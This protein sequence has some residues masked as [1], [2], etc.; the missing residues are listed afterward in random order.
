MYIY[1][2]LIHLKLK[3]YIAW[4]FGVLGSLQKIIWRT[5][6]RVT[7]AFRR[8]IFPKLPP[9]G[10]ESEVH[11]VATGVEHW[12][13]Q[14]SGGSRLDRHRLQYIYG[15]YWL[16][17]YLGPSLHGCQSHAQSGERA[18]A[19]SHRKR[20]KARE[21]ELQFL[22]QPLDMAKHSRRVVFACRCRNA[23]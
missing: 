19:R 12:R 7:F 22:E 9:R 8:R 18:G 1:N 13:E 2:I 16:V 5:D 3:Q 21:I 4:G 20:I 15:H 6:L 23:S 17:C 10:I 14:R 11:F